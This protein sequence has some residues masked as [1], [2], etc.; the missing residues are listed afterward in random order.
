M[1]TISWLVDYCSETRKKYP[2]LEK[3]INDYYE[4]CMTEIDDGGAIPEEIQNLVNTIEELITNHQ[5]PYN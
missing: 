5:K 1:T 2:D 3:Q 4:L